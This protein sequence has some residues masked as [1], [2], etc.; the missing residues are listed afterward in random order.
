MKNE[1]YSIIQQAVKNLNFDEIP[2][3]TVEPPPQRTFGDLSS[4]VAM[5]I[6][7][8]Q[9]RP[10]LE[11]AEAIIEKIKL[12][13]ILSKVQASPPGFINFFV[14]T[15]YLINKTIEI[16]K[17]KESYGKNRYY[18]GKKILLEF[19]SANPTGPLH[20]GHGRWAV[21]GDNIANLF[22]IS[23]ARVEKEYYVNDTG[24]QIDRL[25]M[26]LAALNQGRPV[27]EDG[28]GGAYTKTLANFFKHADMVRDKN[29]I[30]QHV[31][32]QHKHTLKSLRVDFDAWFKES[33]LHEKKSVIRTINTL[34]KNKE[35]YREGNALW[36]KSTAYEDDKDRVLIREDG[37]PTYFSADIAYHL[38]KYQRGYD[39]MVD[40]WGTDHHGYIQRIYAAIKALKLDPKKLEIIIGQ[41]V[42]LYRGN[43][44]VKMSK[45]TG[46]LIT[47]DEVINEIGVDAT[48]FFMSLSD[49]HTHMDFDLELAKAKSDEN[50]V[51]YVQYAHARICSILNEVKKR[52]FKKSWPKHS[53]TPLLSDA[54]EKALMLQLL[55]FPDEVLKAAK[56]RAPHYLAKYSKDLA[57][58]FHS[59]YHKC[60]VISEDSALST[61]RV[62]L[63]EATRITLANVLKLLGIT[64]PERM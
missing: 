6:A 7:K 51:F 4:N 10:P 25:L 60:R 56:A 22:K 15:D 23:G 62:S 12:G 11:I 30:I 36:F 18:H 14:S 64:A 26:S 1:I 19:V 55:L 34:E 9:K 31:L 28:Y 38:N 54:S 29:K 8:A 40:I 27:P 41:L 2:A 42:T 50:P 33:V 57:A 17:A 39:F 32:S 13:G 49:E 45:R 53:E 44:P 43:E 16:I 48:R 58:I 20:I 46:D 59:F 35:T 52:N 47:L 5:L 24:N 63:V 21:L 61:A 37:L 3:F